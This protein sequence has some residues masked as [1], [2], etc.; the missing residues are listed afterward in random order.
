MSR[1]RRCFLVTGAARGIGRAIVDAAVARG[2][3]V[4]AC[5]RD[6]VAL[7][8]AFALVPSVLRF[9]LDVRD[10]RAWSDVVAR[11]E[12]DRGPID[13]LVN[14]A[15][16]CHPGRFDTIPM[17]AERD[18]IDVNLVGTMLGMRAV[19][20]AFVARDRGHVV[21][22]ASMAAFLPSAELASYSATKHAVRAYT[23]ACAMDLRHTG[24]HFTVVCP[25]ATE[26]PM[27]A[28]MRAERAGSVVFAE[29][30]L[31]ADEV[32][33]AVLGAV[34]E[35]RDEVLVPE[36]PNRAL[37]FFGLFPATLRRGMDRA[38]AEGRAALERSR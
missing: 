22:V 17:S 30:P 23:H 27:L 25:R 26:T 31:R 15:G 1:V 5:D 12:R 20:P 14:N 38:I 34:D 35:P 32:A 36:W 4:A 37:R 3:V 8:D 24:I 19:M 33:N 7:A 29:R 28:A 6:E 13:V 2:D 16:I 10:E 18:V 11:I 21:N 9:V